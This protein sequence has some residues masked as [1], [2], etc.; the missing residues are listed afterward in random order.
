M[1]THHP[2]SPSS[3]ERRFLCPA[4]Y[5]QEKD[6]PSVTNPEATAGTRL[7]A[8]IAE[9]AKTGCI[10]QPLTDEESGIVENAISLLTS[11]LY[12][13]EALCVEEPLEYYA[14]GKLVY[15]GTADI[16]ILFADKVIIIDWKTGH[17]EVTEAENNW[18]GAAYALAAMQKFGKSKAEVVF[19]NPVIFQKSATTFDNWKVLDSQIRGLIETCEKPDAPLVSGDKQCR[20]CKAAIHGTCPLLCKNLTEITT[21]EIALSPS[22]EQ[23]IENM[24][25]EQLLD[26]YE[27]CKLLEPLQ[28]KA[29]EA[30]RN[31][32]RAKGGILGQY[33][34]KVVA[35]ARQILDLQAAYN[36]SNLETKKFLECCS[37]SVPKLETAMM[38]DGIFEEG[39]KT[40]KQKKEAIAK[41]LASVITN[42]PQQERLIKK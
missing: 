9:R 1:N 39:I 12:N 23:L 13:S 42:K 29:D 27:K 26:F 4:S 25:D 24:T 22:P 6:L 10:T 5:R 30:V 34:L 2:F 37:V 11:Y 15:N 19:Y 7:H 28:K 40:Q 20:Y 35:G 41:T 21:S 36:L 16:V 31:R 17:R 33:T 32:C 38:N 18:Q 14:D 8:L 3:L